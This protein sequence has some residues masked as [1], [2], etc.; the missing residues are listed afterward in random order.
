MVQWVAVST[1]YHDRQQG[2][3][4]LRARFCRLSPRQNYAIVSLDDRNIPAPFE[5]PRFSGQAG[6]GDHAATAVLVC[7]VSNSTGLRL[8]IVLWRLFGL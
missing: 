7:R 2:R 5:L 6:L 8:P 1:R 4:R 3:R